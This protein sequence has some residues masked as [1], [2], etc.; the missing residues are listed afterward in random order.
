MTLADNQPRQ[1]GDLAC[2]ADEYALLSCRRAA[3]FI[4]VGQF[5][6][7]REVLGGFWRGV[8]ARPSPGAL[9]AQATAEVLL[10]CGVL[11]GWMGSSRHIADAQEAAKD[12]LSEALRF[13]ETLGQQ[14]KVSEARYELSICYWRAG[15][16]DEARITLTKALQGLGAADSELRVKILVRQTLI[17]ISAHRYR[18]AWDILKEAEPV[19]ESTSDALKGRWHG[20]RALVLLQLATTER[21]DEYFDRAI[22]EFTAA[23]FHY[24]QAKH[25]RLWGAS[26][27]N[28]AFLLYKLGR[29]TE[30]HEQLDRARQVFARLNDSGVAAQ[31]DETRARVFV[32]EGRYAE[33]KGVIAGAVSALREGGEQALLADALVVEGGVLARLGDYDAS[34]STL[35]EAVSIAET[36]GA[37]ESAGHA[38]L[39]LV[40]EHGGA[41]LSEEELIETYRRADE[42]LART[43]DADDMARLRACAQVV[44]GRLSGGHI[45]E[46]FSLPRA[47]RAYEARFIERALVD[48]GGSV[49]RAARRLGVKHQSLAHSLQ[50]RHRE[51]SAARTPAVPRKRSIIRVRPQ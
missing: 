23:I 41:R 47:V 5:E 24:E 35:A 39:S 7:A 32:A 12:L 28:L 3:E 51:L 22:I 17:E 30:A 40:E 10:Q 18:E 48:E 49:S 16:L 9:S 43:Q 36:A 45:P 6:D 26:L 44:L 29:Y 31:V 25:E 13:F 42:L 19:F 27:N 15:A 14:S 21:R 20:Q 11:S 33:A 1:V 37:P 34:V 46:G 4:F 50:T 8:G 38:A 2:D